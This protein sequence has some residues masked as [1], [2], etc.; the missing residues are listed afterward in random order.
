AV[1]ACLRAQPRLSRRIIEFSVLAWCFVAAVQTFVNPAF[2]TSLIGSW[3]EVAEGVVETGRGVLGLA[4][5]P[6]HHAF[7]MIIVGA[8]LMILRRSNGLA[9]LCVADAM[10]L[11]RSASA[12]LSLVLGA[13]VLFLR[14]PSRLIAFTLVVTAI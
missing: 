5:E 3:S 14:K 12:L 2:M 4:P 13:G 11:A 6:T 1:L 7:H 10:L 9:S 8:S